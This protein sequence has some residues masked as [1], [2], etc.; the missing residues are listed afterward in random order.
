MTV[1]QKEHWLELMV[2]HLVVEWGH[3]IVLVQMSEAAMEEHSCY[4]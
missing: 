1:G 2:G 3:L 4:R